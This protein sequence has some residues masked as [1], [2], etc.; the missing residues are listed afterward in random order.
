M[1]EPS[2]GVG[3]SMK[4]PDYMG[5]L[6]RGDERLHAPAT[7]RNRDPIL[8]VLRDALPPS[9]YVLELASGSGEHIVHFAECLPELKWQ[10]SDADLEALASIEAWRQLSK[11]SNI[12]PPTALDV[13]AEEWDL[14]NVASDLVGVLAINLIHIAPWD[15][16]EGLIQGS[17]TNV[18]QGGCLYFYGP[19]KRNG[20]HTAASN[21]SFDEMLRRHDPEWGVRDLDTVIEHATHFGLA[22]DRI[23]E[24]PSNNLSVVLR[25]PS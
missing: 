9:G 7:Q 17:A 19:F 3:A 14:P 12:L 13:T 18:T 4:G 20:R 10:P 16:C 1:L 6:G 23:V 21:Q 8:E 25:R 11:L 24:M 5:E 22:L 2:S 15:A